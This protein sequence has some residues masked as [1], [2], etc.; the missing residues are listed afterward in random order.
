[1]GAYTKTTYEVKNWFFAIGSEMG[2]PYVQYGDNSDDICTEILLQSMEAGIP[3]AFQDQ[4]KDFLENYNIGI[5]RFRSDDTSDF[6]KAAIHGHLDWL[7]HNHSVSSVPKHSYFIMSRKLK[8]LVITEKGNR[9]FFEI[10]TESDRF[11]I[12]M[13]FTKKQMFV[14]RDFLKDNNLD[15]QEL[16]SGTLSDLQSTLK[17]ANPSFYMLKYIKDYDQSRGRGVFWTYSML[18]SDSEE[19]MRAFRKSVAGGFVPAYQP[20]VLQKPSFNGLTKTKSQ[21]ITVNCTATNQYG[22]LYFHRLSNKGCFVIKKQI[23]AF[24]ENDKFEWFQ[25]NMRTEL[26]P[27]MEKLL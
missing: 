17:K 21:Q 24:I 11:P 18:S 13:S 2:F 1:M 3:E 14:L 12:R 15:A 4:L 6:K 26:I 8:D 9:I 27:F 16:L 7:L 10:T 22:N 19:L 23:V 25:H 20:D 5:V